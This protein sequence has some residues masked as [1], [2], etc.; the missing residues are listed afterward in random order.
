MTKTVEVRTAQISQAEATT[1]KVDS[2]VIDVPNV[3]EDEV[4]DDDEEE[5]DDDE[6]D[7]DEDCS[8]ESEDSDDCNEF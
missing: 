4:D 8:S 1:N 7:D 3:A 5:E 2:Q 6:D